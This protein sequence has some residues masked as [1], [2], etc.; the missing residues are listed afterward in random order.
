MPVAAVSC[1]DRTERAHRRRSRLGRLS[2]AG[3]LGFLSDG[4]S[5]LASPH[6]GNEAVGCGRYLATVGGRRALCRE[7][8][9][10]VLKVR[11]FPQAVPGQF[12]QI[13]CLSPRRGVSGPQEWTK[14]RGVTAGAESNSHLA[15]HEPFL[16]RPFSIAGLARSGEDCEIKIIGRVIGSGTAWLNGLDGGACVDILGP[17]G[18]GFERPPDRASVLLIA[19]G[20]GLPPILW[21]S[22]ELA[23]REAE[24]LAIYGARSRDFVP[25]SI[26][27]EPSRSGMASSCA[28]E[29]AR[30]GIPLILATE[31]GSC[32]V[33]GRVTDALSLYLASADSSAHILVYACGPKA[34]LEGVAGMCRGA[35]AACQVAMERVMGCGMGTCQSCVIPV[36]DDQAPD[37]W[38]YALCCKEGPVFDARRVVW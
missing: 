32:G 23:G 6:V 38:R 9:E 20:V 7:H 26:I 19:G 33:R 22:D 37:G 2:R 25:L 34:M 28:A 29:F 27:A 1:A 17:L 21:L 14:P 13:H 10:V 18:R 11:G 12:I 24:T 30:N 36:H 8:F 31:D 4:K 35:G 5:R 16:R 15:V 3:S